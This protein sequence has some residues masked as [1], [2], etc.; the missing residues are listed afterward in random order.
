MPAPATGFPRFR[1]VPPLTGHFSHPRGYARIS[2]RFDIVGEVQGFAFS[3]GFPVFPEYLNGGFAKC[4]R[5]VI[6]IP[7]FID[8]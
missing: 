5:A 4:S 6:N 1:L 7:V 2:G 8:W 3:Q